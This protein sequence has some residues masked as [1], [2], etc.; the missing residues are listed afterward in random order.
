MCGIFALL[1]NNE[2]LFP[3]KF[4]EEQF[5]E[6]K[7][8]GPENSTLSNVHLNAVFGFH[9][10]AINGLNNE[11]NQPI[12][13]DNITL[14]CN[15]EIYNYRELYKDMNVEPTTGS[16][17]EVIIH[18][19]LKYGI[20]HTL[21]MLDGVFS[22]ILLDGRYNDQ[23]TNMYVARDPYGVR[24][25]FWL[26][27]S[28]PE[29]PDCLYSFAS[30]LKML[31]PFLN[32]IKHKNGRKQRRLTILDTTSFHHIETKSFVLEPFRPGTYATFEL[33]WRVNAM[34]KLSS[35][36]KYHNTGFNSNIPMTKTNDEFLQGIQ[37]HFAA[38]VF[39]RCCTTDR[40]IACLLSG[41]LDSSLVTALVSDYH[42]IN[43]LSPV[44]TYSIGLK[45]SE[46][47]KCAKQV[48]DYLG[49]KHT[50]I[51]VLEQDFIVI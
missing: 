2:S 12:K 40:P 41:G 10:L 51:I 50:E 37:K 14:I 32:K 49:T 1:N 28:D 35:T 43:G 30:E 11:S 3:M 42:R 21:Q 29:S 8:R 18:L 24:P 7:G 17:C 26:R 4:I 45:G 13:H 23:T 20:E 16:D 47:L 27:N 31:C 33:P 6:G 36:I 34:W 46:D 39:K 9:R 38:A 15:G 44:E 48:A 22:F 25:L 5:D 19:Y